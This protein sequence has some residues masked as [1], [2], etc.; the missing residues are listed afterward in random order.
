MDETGAYYTERSKSE[1]KTPIQDINTYIE[2]RKMVMMTLYARQQKR[3]KEQTF[4]LC[5]RRW[6]WDD[7]REEHWNIHYHMWNR[8]P[9]QVWCVK[10][11]TQSRCTRMTLRDEVGRW[12]EGFRMGDTAHGVQDGRHTC[13]WFMSMYGTNYHNTVI[14]LQL[15]I[16]K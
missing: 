12:E 4:G 6:G 2:F 7:F 1:R 15:K 5:G 10:Q 3:Y 14:S 16:Y 11:G 9:V 8:S 13:G